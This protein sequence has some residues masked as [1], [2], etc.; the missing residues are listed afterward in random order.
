MRFSLLL[1]A[2][3]L[4][5][6]CS[7]LETDGGSEAAGAGSGVGGTTSSHDGF[8]GAAQSCATT[9]DCA[10]GEMCVEGECTSVTA[11]GSV[12]LTST[13][14]EANLLLVLDRSCSMNSG[15]FPAG[16]KW[17]V[18]V[19]A[20]DSMTTTYADGLRFGMLLFPDKTSDSCTQEDPGVPVSESGGGAIR[21][22]LNASLDEEHPMH[23]GSP[24]K[25]N[26]DTAIEQASLH[27]DLQDN[28]RPNHVVLITDGRQSGCTM[29]GGDNGT[30]EMIAELKAHDITTFVVG[31]GGGVDE[32]A[33]NDFAELGGAALPG[34]TK[35]FKAED[36]V[37]LSLALESIAQ[38]SL[39]CSVLL[40]KTEA[41]G[42][43]YVFFN[44]EQSVPEDVSQQEGWSYDPMT[45]VLTFFGAAC[46]QLKSGAVSDLDIVFGCPAPTPQ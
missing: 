15:D 8:G 12:E 16:S 14:V 30:R 28:D 36:D 34:D 1:T 25:T 40:D 33:L 21:E 26:I 17:N 46:E 35:Y 7:G 10:E 5:A 41:A 37:S 20:I 18:A 39:S 31:F 38:Q 23:P 19:A 3:L 2:S 27:P 45:G 24:C 11:C 32:V 22:L 42:E 43:L 44:D 6:G 13:H 4:T 9:E 29:A